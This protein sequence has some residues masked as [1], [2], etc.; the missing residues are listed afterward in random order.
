MDYRDPKWRLRNY[1]GCHPMLLELEIV[2]LIGTEYGL[3]RLGQLDRCNEV[4]NA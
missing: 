1:W 2:Y 3:C 4:F